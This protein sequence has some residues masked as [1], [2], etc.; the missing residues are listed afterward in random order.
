M[1]LTFNEAPNIRRTIEQLTW[2][3]EIVVI[4]SFSTDNTLE[5][6]REFPKVRVLQRKFDTFANQCNFGLQHIPTDWVLSLDADYVLTV[7]LSRE[8]A[9]LKLSGDVSGFEAEFRYCIFGRALRSSLYPARAVLYRK[10]KARYVDVGHGHKVQ[11]DGPIHRLKGKIDHDDRKPL[12]RWVSEQNRYMVREV[13]HLLETPSAHLNLPDRLRLKL[14]IAPF[15]VLFYT[16]IYKRLIFD[17]WPG[18]FY[19]FQ[20]TFAEM[21]LSLRLLEARLSGTVDKHGAGS[22]ER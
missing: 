17:G 8:I 6:F 1:I 9:N 2:A 14:I 10:S 16:L 4:D 19:V 3:A 18:W 15:L 22:A 5:S 7:E 21:L 11:I 20:R 12:D 13:K